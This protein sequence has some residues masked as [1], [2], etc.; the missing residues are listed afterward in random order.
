MIRNRKLNRLT[1]FD[2]S[3]EGYYFVT[4]CV[5]DKIEWFGEIKDGKMILNKFGEIVLRCWDDLCNHYT[6]TKLDEFMI[7][8]N[9][10]HGI[11][12]I[13]SCSR[14]RFETVPYQETVPYKTKHGV[15]EIVRGLK[16]FS[17]RRI[18]E[19]I[20]DGIK[21]QWK[22][23]F[24]DHIIRN[25]QDL[26]R[27]REYIINNPLKWEEDTENINNPYGTVS[28]RSI[29]KKPTYTGHRQR[30]KDKYK[31]SGI[32][33][34]LD[35]EILELALSYAIA[36]KDTKP[37]A[38][39]LITRFKTINGI[40]DAEKEEL[41][42]VSGIS[43]HTVLFL[44]LL[45]DIAIL[46]L[47]NGLHKKDLLSSPDLVYNYLKACLKGCKDEEFKTIFLN[48]RNQLIAIETLQ[49]GTV[50]RSVIYPRKIVERALYH[51]AASIIIA[52][53]HPAGT[54]NPSQDDCSTTKAIKDALKTVEIRLLDHI[55]I[56]GN[57]YFSFQIKGLI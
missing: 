40:L 51:H 28:N 24:Y 47:E 8:P 44:R 54:L 26:I 18:N 30:I 10:L 4:I 53:N 38:K 3:N 35:Y 50:N 11:I 17:S 27:V 39:E 20:S 21:F 22:K 7:M 41:K 42:S 2:Y 16:T 32:S 23:S 49:T 1:G 57:G 37:I 5:K 34:W 56:G 25:E 6:N 12:V 9:H 46:Y 33:G 19:T 48:T 45:K 31:K 29:Q 15:S 13:E 43:E 55:I 14:E 36:R 52:H